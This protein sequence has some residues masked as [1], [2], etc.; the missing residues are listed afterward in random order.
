MEAE[1]TALLYYCEPRRPFCAKL[2]HGA[3]QFKEGI[4]IES[5][6]NDDSR[7]C[8]NV[9]V[10]QKVTYL[11]G[12]FEKQSN[13]NKS[14][15]GYQINTMTQNDKF[16]SFMKKLELWKKTEETNIFLHFSYF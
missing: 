10:I 2:L 4:L 7:L 5:N 1:H 13:L 12:I 16:N 9:D 14:L 3:F 6:N 11:A 15:Q 8:Y